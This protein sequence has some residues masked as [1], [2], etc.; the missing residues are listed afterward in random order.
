MKLLKLLVLDLLVLSVRYKKISAHRNDALA[1]VARFSLPVSQAQQPKTPFENRMDNSFIY[2]DSF[3]STTPRKQL[4]SRHDTLSN[5]NSNSNY[6]SPDIAPPF[7]P[8]DVFSRATSALETT[9]AALSSTSTNTNSATPPRVLSH[10]VSQKPSPTKY[11]LPV[12]SS[13]ESLADLLANI[14]AERQKR[15]CAENMAAQLRSELAAKTA[16]ESI[17]ELPI[18]R[19]SPSLSSS[20]R[21]SQSPRRPQSPHRQQ[22]YSDNI[23]QQNK[24]NSSQ[25]FSPQKPPPPPPPPLPPPSLPP[26]QSTTTTTTSLYFNKQH[27]PPKPALIS[28]DSRASSLEI[29]SLKNEIQRLKAQLEAESSGAS[30]MMQR[31]EAAS[32]EKELKLESQIA[33]MNR[34]LS[35]AQAEVASS[36]SLAEERLARLN[37][38]SQRLA[39]SRSD[40]ESAE[41]SLRTVRTE[42]VA[43]ESLLRKTEAELKAE[44][45]KN[46][47]QRSQIDDLSAEILR[48]TLKDEE[49]N[50]R[51]REGSI[52]IASTMA[53]VVDEKKMNA[54]EVKML[55]LEVEVSRLRASNSALH[56]S[57]REVD[58]HIERVSTALQQSE[59]KY[60][61]ARKEAAEAQASKAVALA[62][63]TAR[64]SFAE[65]RRFRNENSL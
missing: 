50:W 55:E 39:T 36:L 41:L 9:A 6:L 25:R 45:E 63:L 3:S 44:V 10:H 12:S 31:R 53:S 33:A 56:N 26:P 28:I 60:S 19:G 30:I 34:Q 16:H 59:Q 52:S 49:K 43:I 51:S 65:K 23:S 38:N 42:F 47:V 61:I 21:R 7:F 14:D 58:S 17:P 27:S 29:T 11:S 62:E 40:A 13:T 54:Q 18:H 1:A 35:Q 15:Q 8:R 37:S 4:P 2:N 46:N 48:L 5:S 64:A 20:P 32:K 22:H 57:L 24:N